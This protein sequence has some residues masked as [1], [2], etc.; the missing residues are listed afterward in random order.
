MRTGIALGS[1][2]GDRLEHLRHAR[3]AILTLPG[4]DGA[5]ALVAS[6]FRTAPVGCTPGAGWFLNSVVEVDHSGDPGDLLLALREIETRAG[7]PPDHGVNEPR[8][9]DLDI[10]YAGDLIRR[11]DRLTLPHPRMFRRRFVL[12]PL[13]EIRPELILP[14][15]KASVTAIL[16]QLDDNPAA[17]ALADEQW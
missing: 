6:L 2:L 7:R 11:T 10:L 14:G 1:N 4:V 16:E 9:L 3:T 13:S 5:S 8:A 17:V 12:A 15:Q